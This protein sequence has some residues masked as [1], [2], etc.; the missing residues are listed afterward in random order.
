MKAGAGTGPGEPGV[1]A[2]WPKSRS[3]WRY[4]VVAGVGERAPVQIPAHLGHGPGPSGLQQHDVVRSV[5]Q[6]PIV[7]IGSGLTEVDL[8]EFRERECHLT[9]PYIAASA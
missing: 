9:Y 8:K 1:G 7:G 3:V 4:H 6:F 5:P 2:V